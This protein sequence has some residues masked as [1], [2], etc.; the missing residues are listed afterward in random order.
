MLGAA[1]PALLRPC[2]DRMEQLLAT[3]R[4]RAAFGRLGERTLIAWD[5]VSIA[6]AAGSNW[7][8]PAAAGRV[9]IAAATAGRGWRRPWAHNRTKKAR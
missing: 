1:D 3:P 7:H 9:R 5:G 2:F 8:L 4:L 6:L